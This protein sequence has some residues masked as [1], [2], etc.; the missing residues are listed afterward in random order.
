MIGR[1]SAMGRAARLW[2]RQPRDDA[3][4]AGMDGDETMQP[5]RPD[6]RLTYDDFLLFPDDGRRHELIDGE[7]YVTPS[8]NTRH[9]RLVGRLHAAF[10]L[11]LRDHPDAGE[12]FLAPFD[13]V[14]TQFDVVE[15]DLLFI[16]SD[17]RDIVTEKHVRGAPAIVIEILSPGTRKVDE[18]VKYRLFE[19]SGVREYWVV[20]PELD[21]TKVHRRSSN[22]SFSRVGEITAEQ[23]DTLATPLLPG[24]AVAL[25]E[26]F[27]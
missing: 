20:D 19:Q 21:L 12:A 24:F 11:Y 9:Q 15:P 27:R 16:S 6:T 23:G 3:T 22:G 4:I 10:V 14:F 7:H 8:P 26:L 18:K 5:A 1:M 2:H 17:Q 25:S 13:V